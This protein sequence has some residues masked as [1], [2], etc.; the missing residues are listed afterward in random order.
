M[1]KADISKVINDL[2]EWLC[3]DM[4]KAL[5]RGYGDIMPT[6]RANKLVL[7]RDVAERIQWYRDN[8]DDI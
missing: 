6:D 3:R 4:E 2:G 1:D 5:I 7:I 8:L